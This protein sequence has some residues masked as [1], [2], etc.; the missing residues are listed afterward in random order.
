M[1]ILCYRGDKGSLSRLFGGYAI[2][3]LTLGC[4][5]ISGK[6]F[7]KIIDPKKV[8]AYGLL[9][10]QHWKWTVKNYVVPNFALCM[11]VITYTQIV[12]K[13]LDVQVNAR[14]RKK[15]EQVKTRQYQPFLLAKHTT[16]FILFNVLFSFLG[17]DSFF[18]ELQITLYLFPS[19]LLLTKF[20]GQ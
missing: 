16:L 17:F 7:F 2:V 9:A 13:R 14:E 15:Y 4:S 6:L 5:N 11:I 10:S 19:V 3:S 18:I 8:M 12:L 20:M 1:C